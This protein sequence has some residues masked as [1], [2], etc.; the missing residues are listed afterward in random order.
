MLPCYLEVWEKASWKSEIFI[1]YWAALPLR[2]NSPHLHHLYF[3]LLGNW[4]FPC[5]VLFRTLR[6]G[7]SQPPGGRYTI[8]RPAFILPGRQDCWPPIPT[9]RGFLKL[10][11]KCKP[12][13]H[14]FSP[15]TALCSLSSK[16]TLHCPLSPPQIFPLCLKNLHFIVN[17]IPNPPQTLHKMLSSPLHSLITL[18]PGLLLVQL[19]S[20]GISSSFISSLCCPKFKICFFSHISSTLIISAI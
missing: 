15:L 6:E 14:L 10:H 17:K 9:I 19:L 11:P 4:T 8:C 20:W 18:A 2:L 3:H 13:H 5:C 1:T 16:L 7:H 12:L